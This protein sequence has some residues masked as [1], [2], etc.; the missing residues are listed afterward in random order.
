M[1]F[2]S[3]IERIHP[4]A[5]LAKELKLIAETEFN[6]FHPV[7]RCWCPESLTISVVLMHQFYGERLVRFCFR[8]WSHFNI[9]AAGIPFQIL[10]SVFIMQKPF[11]KGVSSVSGDA[12]SVLPA[13]Y[14]LDQYLTKLY[15]SALEANKLPNSFNQDFK[16]YQVTICLTSNF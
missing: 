6:V 4:L 8:F 9:V 11:L 2:E 1:D 3:K 10:P 14:M 16:H 5:Q 13:A 15:T 7:L 12:R